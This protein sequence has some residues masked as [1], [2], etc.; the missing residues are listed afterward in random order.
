MPILPTR[1]LF[2]LGLLLLLLAG[3]DVADGAPTP[4]PARP[5]PTLFPTAAPA[6]LETT[7]APPAQATA[8]PDTGWQP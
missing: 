5:I 4:R 6:P 3:C 8:A 1:R 2:L 7:P